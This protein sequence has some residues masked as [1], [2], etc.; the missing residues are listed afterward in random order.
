MFDTDLFLKEYFEK[1][2]FEKI[3]NRRQQKHEKL[4]SMQRAYNLP[5]LAITILLLAFY[6]FHTVVPTKSDSDDMF[7]LQLLNQ[8]LACTHNLSLCES[9]DHLCINPILRIGLIH[10]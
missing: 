3:V 9:I 4:P 6:M 8:T 2:N 5:H 1:V 7:C 10:K